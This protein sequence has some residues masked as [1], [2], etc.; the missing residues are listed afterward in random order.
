MS[1][2]AWFPLIEHLVKL[3]EVELV[4]VIDPCEGVFSEYV[5]EGRLTHSQCCRRFD[6]LPPGFD[7]DGIIIATPP[8][9][10][11]IISLLAAKAGLHILCEKPFA[12]DLEAA[13][14]MRD[15]ARD[16]NLYLMVGQ[17]RRHLSCIHT[18][19]K[20]MNDSIY[21]DPGQVYLAFRQIF[22]RPSYRDSMAHPL[23]FDM[24]IHHFDSIRYVLGKE[25]TGVSAHEWNPPWSRFKG[26][27]SGIVLFDFAD[28]LRVVYDASWA[29][30]N[31][32]MTSNAG[33]WRIECEEGVILCENDL[34][35]VVDKG[36]FA[37][38]SYGGNRRPAEMVTMPNE[39]IVYLMSQF[40]RAIRY[41]E[42]P[43]TNAEDNILTLRM[44]LGAITSSEGGSKVSLV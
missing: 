16:N 8:E 7:A 5:Q 28:S 30:M 21:G 32:E 35:Y 4:A 38:G 34:V 23:L 43:D 14:R 3:G 2:M 37:S 11:E 17:S 39:S 22:T 20:L 44:V 27:A 42:L 19:R 10:H 41:G 26:P 33:D 1:K 24:A 18:M 40:L 29:T 36:E 9:T 25:P 13:K 31:G 15:A 12:P 6:E